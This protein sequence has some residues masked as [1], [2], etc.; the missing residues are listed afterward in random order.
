MK[1]LKIC[2]LNYTVEYIQPNSREDTFMGRTDPQKALITINQTMAE[3][4]QQQTL[5]HEWLHA[6][7][8]NYS[9][10]ENENETMIQAL[11]TELHNAGFKL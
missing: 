2:G 5:I 8:S 3:D 7:L 9:L 10:A 4:V 11:A 6:I 1:K